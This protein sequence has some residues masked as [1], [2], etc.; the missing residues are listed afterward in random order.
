[1]TYN[2]SEVAL[3]INGSLV[4]TFAY[5][6][7]ISATTVPVTIGKRLHTG[8]DRNFA[9]I[10]DEVAIYNRAL[11]AAEVQDHYKAR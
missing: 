9:G 7:P 10:E 5:T 3:Y 11:S 6:A 2:R 1:M 4:Q 8:S